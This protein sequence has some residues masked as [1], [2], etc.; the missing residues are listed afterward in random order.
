M[1]KNIDKHFDCIVIGAGHA[2][3]EAAHAAA[4]IGAKTLL[5][6][7]SRETIA[8]A[9][10]N[11]AIG[12]IA[13]GQIVREIDALGGIMALATDMAGLQ[14]RIL[15]RSK[16]AAVRS[17]RAQ[18]DKYL[19]SQIV[20]DI[21]EKTPNL[22]IE[23]GLVAE[24][25]TDNNQT[26]GVRCTDGRAF[27]APA[28][29]VTTGTFLKGIMH[30]GA[31]QWPGGR[32]NEPAANE[33]SDCLR[34]LGFEVGRLKTG[35][36]ARLNADTIDYAQLQK[37]IG[38]ET[39]QPFSFMTD[40]I[41]QEQLPCWITYTN[42]DVH[43]LLLDN[44]D[45]APLYTGQITTTGPRY[46]PSIETKVQ[47]FAD[48]DQ[49]QIFLEP[50]DRQMTTI[51]CNGI[52][53]SVPEDIQERMLK[54][55]VGLENA[56][57]VHYAYAIEYDYCPAVQLKPN[58]ET[59]K[60]A[61]LFLAGQINGTSGYEEAAGQ[62]IIAGINAARLIDKKEP[63]I[64]GRDIAYIGVMIDDLLTREIDEPYRMFT[65]RAEWR[66][67]LRSDN[68]DRRLTQIGKSV[69]LVDEKRW[70]KFEQK[71]SKIEEITQ[72]LKKTSQNGANF[73]QNLKKS[74]VFCEKLA[75]MAEIR[76]HFDL[77]ILQAAATDSKYEGYLAKQEKTV[78]AAKKLEN[79]VLPMDLDYEKIVHLRA[80][81]KQKLTK[82]RPYTLGQA[83][84]IGGITPADITVVQIYL[85]KNKNPK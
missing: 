7:I 84:R 75:Q 46:C 35:T 77:E 17:P 4:A 30:T 57:I 53:T 58:L 63:L 48:K 29:I 66:L 54:M 81:A 6:T 65:S 12:G 56:K 14:F 52:S 44:L 73:W 11:P 18:I 32:L 55:I 13:K 8:K 2:G 1:A 76:D 23:E 72:F 60:I 45:K 41:T 9:S 25:L 39:P 70:Q 3:A 21:L 80:E 59:K 47:R 74:D 85:K 16:G 49:H 78:L 27:Y 69:G 22:T 36:P 68:A 37:Q 19:Y 26:N 43:K 62:G 28:V 20:R 79:F 31:K 38:D 24:I 51:Y 67:N 71:L 64:L 33:L 5:L 82:F 15:N 34:N 61:G 42:P 83:A 50:E 10:C 40:S